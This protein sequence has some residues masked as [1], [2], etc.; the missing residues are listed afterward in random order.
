MS[1][2]G[3]GMNSPDGGFKPFSGPAIALVV[4]STEAQ[5]AIRAA[6][7]MSDTASLAYNEAVAIRLRRALNVAALRGAL[8][9]LV[10]RHESRRAVFTSDGISML[11][12][13][14]SSLEAPLS[15]LSSFAESER[16][17]DRETIL[18]DVVTSIFDLVNG[19]L[20][21]AQLLRRG[22]E[23]HEL[24]LTAH[25]IVCDG[26][27]FGVIDSDLAALYNA[28]VAGTPLTVQAPDRFSEYARERVDAVTSPE[29]RADATKRVQQFR[30]S[31]PVLNH[32]TDRARPALKTYVA[33]RVDR[34]VP[35]DVVRALRTTGARAGVS[36]FATLLGG[37]SALLHRLTGQDDLVVAVP[38][39]GP[40]AAG[41]PSLVGHCVAML[42]IRVQPVGARPMDEYLRS[43]SSIALDGFEL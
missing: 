25:H 4:P 3:S 27:S 43:V 32:P 13:E 12:A 42:P 1:H 24:V 37:Y 35:S 31:V 7:Q 9:D 8:N 5:R 36:L 18:R 23:M 40:S 26:W 19:P 34:V 22:E 41:K 15:D 38:V 20:I 33:S 10:A 28:R 6:V 39:P 17:R 16:D 30:G 14:S 2:V 21:R 11:V 29:R